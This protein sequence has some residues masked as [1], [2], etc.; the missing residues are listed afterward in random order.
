MT[1]RDVR[2]IWVGRDAGRRYYE[3][4]QTDLGEMA[5]DEHEAVVVH[6]DLKK[7]RCLRCNTEADVQFRCIHIHAVRK[8]L[9]I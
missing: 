2:E 6:E 7:L 4:G 5:A 1:N 8:T 9:D 3:V